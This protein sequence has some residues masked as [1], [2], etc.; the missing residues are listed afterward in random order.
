MACSLVSGAHAATTDAGQN[1][2]SRALRLIAPSPAG[3][4]SDF[5]ARILAPKLSEYLRQNIVVDNRQSV[6][7]IIATEMVAKAAPDGLTLGIGNLGTHVINLALYKSLPY[8]PIRDFIAVSQ[9]ISNGSALVGNV[10]LVPRNLKELIAYA[11]AN[12]G[13][14]NIGIAGANGAA[15][16][17]IFKSAA[18]IV[19]NNIPYKGSA[20]AE[21]AVISGE[22]ELVQLSI[23]VVAG[24]YK[25][26]RLK[27]YGIMSPRRSP[28]LPD[29][30]TIAEQ[31][32][33]GY[34]AS[35]NWHGVFVPA[36]TPDRIV[37]ILHR[38]IVRVFDA[39]D[40]REI[41]TNR[42]SDL[43]VNTP[44]QF[45]A[46]LKREVPKMRK[47]MHDAGIVPQ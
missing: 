14:L 24:H 37:C 9:L 33:P 40:I 38:E 16:T 42:G 5:A 22:V 13:K 11:R 43:I 12:P 3:G 31:G 39:P 47:I 4:P 41:I 7:G 36:K 15:G 6:N 32:L 18:G 28:L 17:A 27:V 23:P 45:A 21:V 20:P 19:L 34:E 30:L 35:G 10:K 1:Y 44:E 26:G 25:A 8:D 29:V 2:P 46:Y